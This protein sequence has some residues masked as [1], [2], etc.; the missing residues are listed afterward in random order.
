MTRAPQRRRPRRVRSLREGLLGTVLGTEA[1][2]MFFTTLTAFGLKALPAAAAFAG[3]GALLL[4]LVLGAWLQRYRWGHWVGWVL[5]VALIAT[6]FVLPLMF[7][8]GAGFAGFY[9]FCYV[10]ARQLEARGAPA[11]GEP[12]AGT[13]ATETPA[14][15][16]PSNADDPAVRSEEETE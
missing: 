12:A 8:I 15:G 1:A 14:G 5:Q 13:A 4:L 11:P 2:V 16:D 7:V 6:G 9:V 10:K 3:G